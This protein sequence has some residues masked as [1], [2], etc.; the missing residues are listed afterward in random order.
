VDWLGEDLLLLALDAGR[1]R[2][3]RIFAIGYGLM[4]AE[5]VQLAACGRIDIVDDQ[6]VVT[7]AAPT[8]DGELDAALARI[9][10]QAFPPWADEWVQRV[11]PRITGHYLERLMAAG[12][13][14]EQTRFG[15]A[16]WP[17]TGP[18]RLAEARQR[19]DLIACSAG[20]V[21][22]SQAAYAGLACAIGLD[23]VL[24]PG[25]GR[26]AERDRLREFATG[27]WATSPALASD[28]AD[29]AAAWPDASSEEDCAALEAAT[30]DAI[31]AAA[32]GVACAA[33]AEI[34]AAI[35][36]SSP[37][38]LQASM[39]VPGQLEGHVKT[40]AGRSRG[41][42]PESQENSITPACSSRQSWALGGRQRHA[43]HPFRRGNDRHSDDSGCRP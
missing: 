26:R 3:E 15:V 11:R 19:L 10:E 16:R 36:A 5:L 41:A 20:P 1:G 30:L 43:D 42:H 29:A 40:F 13:V 31:N 21:D 12:V 22:L 8:G 4:G 24:Y 39:V 25:R 17:I 7:S 32:Y 35:V 23:R 38:E 2:L 27:R 33:A 18:A 14:G 37:H 28:S 34:R 9:G 6:I